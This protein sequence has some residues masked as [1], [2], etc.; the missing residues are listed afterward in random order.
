[1]RYRTLS[2]QV[3]LKILP[4]LRLDYYAGGDCELKL[5][6]VADETAGDAIEV[7]SQLSGDS[8]LT[9]IFLFSLRVVYYQAFPRLDRRQVV[10]YLGV[11]GGHG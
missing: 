11:S 8:W 5:G 9:R 10:G 4:R 2:H 7:L 3:N 6:G 1:M